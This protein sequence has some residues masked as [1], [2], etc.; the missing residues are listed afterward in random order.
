M[1]KLLLIVAL[2]MGVTIAHGQEYKI[3]CKRISGCP[4]IN[5]TCPTCEIVGGNNSQKEMSQ[6]LDRILTEYKAENKEYFDD[7]SWE[8]KQSNKNPSGWDTYIYPTWKG[9]RVLY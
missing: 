8:V 1:K 2:S 7:I 5:G 6:K 4:V 9:I 3:I